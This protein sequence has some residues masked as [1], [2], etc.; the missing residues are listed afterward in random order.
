M[1]FK[2]VMM[3]G[4]PGDEDYDDPVYD[5]VWAAAV[6]L[7]LPLSFHILTTSGDNSLAQ[8]RAAP[9]STASCRII[10]G[11]QDIMG[12]LIFCGVFDRHPEL[13][14]VCVEADAGWAPHYM[15][16][17]DHAYKR[18]RYWMKGRSSPACRGVFPRAHLR[19]P[20][21]TTGWRSRSPTCSVRTGSC[22]PTTSRT[23]ISTW[24][25]SQDVIAEQAAHLSPALRKRILRDN[26][27]ELYKLAA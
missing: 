12:T 19:S 2:G 25:W 5:P 23:A 24:P 13:N 16:R 27:V 21:R 4:D 6:E 7:D 26:V 15:Y 3:P 18:H 20:S 22:G 17:M 8:N 9:A 14:V 11:C 1:G 10:R